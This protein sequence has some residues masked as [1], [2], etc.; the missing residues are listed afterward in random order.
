MKRGTGDHPKMEA[1]ALALNKEIYAAV[2][3]LN[4]MWDWAARF[5]PSG[6]IGKYSDA[7]I[8]RKIGWTGDPAELVNALV[9]SRWLDRSDIC[10]LFIHD[11]PD[12]CEDTV[13]AT[14]ARHGQYFA[15]GLKPK[16]VKLGAK[17]KIEA[18]IRYAQNNAANG[19]QIPPEVAESRPL[20]VT[21]PLPTQSHNP[22]AAESEEIGELLPE[23]AKPA[24]RE[25]VARASQQK[26]EPVVAQ[27]STTG[28]NL[29]HFPASVAIGIAEIDVGSTGNLA[30]QPAARRY[31]SEPKVPK[32]QTPKEFEDMQDW[33]DLR[34]SRHPKKSDILLDRAALA[35]LYAEGELERAKFDKHQEVMSKRHR[36]LKDGANFCPKLSDYIKNRKY[37]MPIPN[38]DPEDL[39]E[40]SEPDR[41]E[42]PELL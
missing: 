15:N 35:M 19:C 27:V 33:I 18:E 3:I 39:D 25:H 24:Q 42:V 6:D 36:W 29:R 26:S 7:V 30:L 14:L 38:P 21:Y 28:S 23:Y 32:R 40:S 11:W 16:M 8:A 31:A 22:A 41:V 13:H 10:R 1:L 20:P 9:A 4:V 12:H 37:L 17:E 5:T 2:G 34:W